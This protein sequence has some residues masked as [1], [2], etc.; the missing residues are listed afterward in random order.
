MLVC[1]RWM[2]EEMKDHR[3]RSHPQYCT[4]DYDDKWILH[5]PHHDC[6]NRVWR[7]RDEKLLNCCVMHSHKGAVTGIMAWF[8]I[9]FPYRT[10]LVLISNLISICF[11]EYFF[12][13]GS[14][15]R[16]AESSDV[17]EIVNSRKTVYLLPMAL[18]EYPPIR[19][20]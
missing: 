12:Y 9:G 1:H 10:P 13:T 11:T 7:H 17:H 18:T 6:R 14:V 15:A 16:W 2:Q 3:C 20:S 4:T 5:M 19:Q 8:A